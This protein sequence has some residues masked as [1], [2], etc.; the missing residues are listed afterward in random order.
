MKSDHKKKIT[1]ITLRD[2]FIGTLQ[3]VCAWD[4][5]KELKDKL[6]LKIEELKKLEFIFDHENPRNH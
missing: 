1:A 6:L 3:G 5:P 4:I 2:E